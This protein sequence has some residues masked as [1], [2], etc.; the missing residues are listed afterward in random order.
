MKYV[1]HT[2][3]CVAL[4]IAITLVAILGGGHLSA[5]AMAA[6]TVSLG[7]AISWFFGGRW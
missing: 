7:L 1:L 3:I 6:L 5:N 2:I 4:I